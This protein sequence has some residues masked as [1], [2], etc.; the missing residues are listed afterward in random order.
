MYKLL[1]AAFIIFS[2]AACNSNDVTPS[3]VDSVKGLIP[4]ASGNSWFYKKTIY[5]STTGAVKINTGDTI[6]VT[7]QTSINGVFYYQQYQASVPINSASF[8]VNVD[9]NTV[10]KI[11]SAVKY[12]FFK[13]VSADQNI[14]TWAD[15]VNSRCTGHNELRGYAADTTI[16]TYTGVLKNV[17]S[18][19]DCTGQTFQKWVYYLKPGIGLVRIE[20][21]KV[22]A[23]NINFYLDFADDL[24]HYF[25]N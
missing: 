10:Q 14:D 24:D 2:V 21:Y 4:L 11:D 20:H 3:P 19:N 1:I 12:T 8:F 22:M 15:T 9:S 18:V 16:G 5:D 17:V 7:A 25:I 13:R 23:D 6:L